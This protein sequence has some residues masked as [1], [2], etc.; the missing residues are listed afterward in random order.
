MW[1]QVCAK[2]K[3]LDQSREQDRAY[4]S[5]CLSSYLCVL[6]LFMAGVRWR[7]K[8]E[9][10]TKKREKK[11]K[12]REEDGGRILLINRSTQSLEIVKPLSHGGQPWH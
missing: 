9:R 3:G 5:T 6:A 10:K 7:R 1:P 12:E 11:K 2:E 4:S 8:K